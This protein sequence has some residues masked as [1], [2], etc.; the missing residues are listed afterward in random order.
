M[1][2]RLFQKLLKNLQNRAVRAIA[3][4]HYMRETSS[5]VKLAQIVYQWYK[6]RSIPYVH[7]Y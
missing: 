3:K 5:I 2:V 6:A 4:G 7:N 1:A